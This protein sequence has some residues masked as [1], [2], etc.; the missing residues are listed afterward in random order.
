MSGTVYLSGPITGLTYSGARYGWRLEFAEMLDE[1]IK[2]LSPMRHEG[3][4]AEMRDKTI[5]PDNL[6]EGLFSQP[7]MIVTKDFLD[8]RASDIMVVNFSE[9]KKTSEGT[10]IEIGYAAA[11]GKV[12]V[13][14]Q[15]PLSEAVHRSPFLTELGIVVHSLR[16]AAHIV[17]SL[18][19]EGV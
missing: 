11:L 5:E 16:D 2:V 3:H 14:I 8:I 4:L 15:Q 12:I 6:P 7:K 1:G 17:N 13:I 18:L 10:L 9:A 19:S